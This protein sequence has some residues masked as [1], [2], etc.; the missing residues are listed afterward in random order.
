[1]ET[2]RPETANSAPDRNLTPKQ[3]A[4][5]DA[6]LAKHKDIDKDLQAN[7]ALVNDN[8]YLKRHKD[9]QA[10]LDKDPQVQERVRANP[11]SIVPAK[12]ETQTNTG[13]RGKDGSAKSSN[14]K[15]SGAKNKEKT[16]KPQ[17]PD[18]KPKTPIEQR[19]ET[20]PP[21]H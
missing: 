21:V 6:F 14:A 20:Q 8:D 9:L 7:P 15:D 11:S 17:K 13:D 16:Q 19:E 2:S 5:R 1:M 18:D 3:R 12:N 4:D 10:F